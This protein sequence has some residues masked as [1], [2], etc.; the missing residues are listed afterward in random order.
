MSKTSP[1][2]NRG[3][4]TGALLLS[5]IV[6][7]AYILV[8]S[9]TVIASPLRILAALN[10][11]VALGAALVLYRRETAGGKHRAA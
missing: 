3:V 4:L 7:V 5:A 10:L 8:P 1:E 2:F 11:P 6:S 9:G